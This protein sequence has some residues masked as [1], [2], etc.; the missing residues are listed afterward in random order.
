MRNPWGITHLVWTWLDPA[1]KWGDFLPWLAPSLKPH[2]L[3]NT[4]GSQCSRFK[5][6]SL[7]LSFWAWA[8]PSLP[9]TL[10][11]DRVF[12][13]RFIKLIPFLPGLW[14]RSEWIMIPHSMSYIMLFKHEDKWGVSLGVCVAHSISLYL[15]NGAQMSCDCVRGTSLGKSFSFFF[16]ALLHWQMGFD[17]VPWERIG[18]GESLRG[19][20]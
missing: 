12:L 6:I 16:L 9:F 8:N 13:Y 20:C 5:A 14:E 11:P 10:L 7:K 18:A 2:F 1:R 15:T 17:I 3:I 19:I 4:S